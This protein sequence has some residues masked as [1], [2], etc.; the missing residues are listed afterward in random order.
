[1]P[2]TALL[3]KLRELHEQLAEI[4]NDLGHVDQIDDETLNALEEM[5]AEAGQIV[6]QA[7]VLIQPQDDSAKPHDLNARIEQ[8]ETRH[9]RVTS[10][11]SQL[12]DLL[13]MMGI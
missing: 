9:P 5:V 7:N 12:T 1:M 13:A 2:N 8:F 10:F 3:N 4:N 6:D 11:L